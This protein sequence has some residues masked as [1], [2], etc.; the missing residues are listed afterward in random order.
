MYSATLCWY[1]YKCQAGG[2]AACLANVPVG[3][4]IYH[5]V[6]IGCVRRV[7]AVDGKTP[8]E[9]ISMAEEC[10]SGDIHGYGHAN[11]D[12]P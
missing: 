3:G 4:C 5:Q 8:S 1:E 7:P 2:T 10:C 12:A 9:R 11:N 6:G